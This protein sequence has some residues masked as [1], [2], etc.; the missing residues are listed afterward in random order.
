ML[1][2]NIHA[3]MKE[4]QWQRLLDP[5]PESKEHAREMG[6]YVRFDHSQLKECLML[7]ICNKNVLGNIC[8]TCEG[9]KFQIK[10]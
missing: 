6:A 10:T 7:L 5:R 1:C 2:Q 4:T 3:I 9:E 8:F